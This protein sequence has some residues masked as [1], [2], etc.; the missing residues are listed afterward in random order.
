MTWVYSK[1]GTKQELTS[2]RPEG[3]IIDRRVDTYYPDGRI[4]ETR[5]FNADSV[6]IARAVSNYDDRKLLIERVTYRPDDSI[7]I[8]TVYRLDG[9]QLQIE[10]VN[11]DAHGGITSQSKTTK[12]SQGK[13]A[14]YD[15][16]S[17]KSDGTATHADYSIAT[18][19]DG[20]HDFQYEE[21]NGNF[22][23][24]ATTLGEKGTFERV[25]YNR[26]GTIFRRDRFV[27]EFD[28]YRNMIKSTNSSAKG[29]SQDFEPAGVTY[30]T[31]NYYGKN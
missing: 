28:S 7:S 6:L 15:L 17:V 14:D 5:R 19:P 2:Y 25:M 26:D 31:I 4:L 20:G 9:K 29:D 1:D 13:R 3:G 22:R 30:R 27:Q 23:R 24:E 21:S 8:R 10:T 11:Y 16:L 12:S 18:N